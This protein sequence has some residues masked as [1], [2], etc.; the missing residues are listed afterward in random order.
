MEV[1]CSVCPLFTMFIHKRN[2]GEPLA[3]PRN[4]SYINSSYSHYGGLIKAAFHPLA[5]MKIRSHTISCT[6]RLILAL[7]VD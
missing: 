1:I 6:G 3:V 7:K 2:G 5:Y 4:T